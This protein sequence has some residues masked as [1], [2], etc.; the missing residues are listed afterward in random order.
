MPSSPGDKSFKSVKTVVSSSK[1]NG[2]SISSEIISGLYLGTGSWCEKKDGIICLQSRLEG[3][4]RSDGWSLH[5]YNLN[6]K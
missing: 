4:G 5:T 1:E 6:R 3:T 2:A